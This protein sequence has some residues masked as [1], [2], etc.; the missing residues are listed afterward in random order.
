[1]N[2]PLNRTTS[3]NMPNLQN[4]VRLYITSFLPTLMA[5]IIRATFWSSYDE[6]LTLPDYDP[7]DGQFGQCCP[8]RPN[9]RF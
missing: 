9:H 6:I 1:M 2:F 5:L 8:M 3:Q 7:K 4:T